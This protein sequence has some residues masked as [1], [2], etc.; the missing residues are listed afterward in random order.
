MKL[1]LRN[2]RRQSPVSTAVSEG[3]K[4]MFREMGYRF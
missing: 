1:F 2:N 3:I 4:D